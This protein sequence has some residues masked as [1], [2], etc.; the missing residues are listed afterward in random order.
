MSGIEV[1]LND[2]LTLMYSSFGGG[3]GGS[4]LL[5]N[6]E[7]ISSFAFVNAAAVNVF[8]NGPLK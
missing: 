6:I 5:L 2:C 7:L 1:N 8:V 4:W 3:S